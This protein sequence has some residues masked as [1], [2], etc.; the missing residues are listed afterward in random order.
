MNNVYLDNCS[1]PSFVRFIEIQ[2]VVRLIQTQSIV[3]FFC[4]FFFE[5]KFIILGLYKLGWVTFFFQSRQ[6]LTEISVAHL[7]IY[8]CFCVFKFRIRLFRV[9]VFDIFC[10]F[11]PL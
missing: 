7:L 11:V 4:C 5:N 2:R 1:G 10:L 9:L 6:H 3:F 8:Y